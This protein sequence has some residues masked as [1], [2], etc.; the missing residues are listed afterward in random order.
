[1]PETDITANPFHNLV[2]IG[3][4]ATVDVDVEDILSELNTESILS[5]MDVDE[6]ASWVSNN[7][8]ANVAV[9]AEI[10]S[11]DLREEL[12]N[13]GDYYDNLDISEV[14][15]YIGVEK[16]LNEMDINDI[17]EFVAADGHNVYGG[18]EDGIEITPE[19]IAAFNLIST[20]IESNKPLEGSVLQ[21]L[22]LRGKRFI[23]E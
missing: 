7:Y 16:I 1:M 9:L 15:D 2:T 18:N 5:S 8:H 6:V 23:I 4:Y 17:I 10:E 19:I 3:H 12:N 20:F 13:R 22:H 21:A 14:I 11:D